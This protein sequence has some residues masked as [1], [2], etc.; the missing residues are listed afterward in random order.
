MNILLAKNKDEGRKGSSILDEQLNYGQLFQNH[1]DSNLVKILV[2]DDCPFNVVA[3][4][5]LIM[6]FN[7]EC[8]FCS[9]GADA[10]KLVKDRLAQGKPV[11]RL[12][13]MDF[14]MPGCDGPTATSK[15]R[16]ELQ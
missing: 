5:A 13:L 10:V 6:Q 8:E 9:N 16:A 3:I 7:L 15:I 2:V 1:E 14:S 11:Y 4:Q 12:I